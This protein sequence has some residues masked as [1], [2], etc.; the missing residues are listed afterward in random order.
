[1]RTNSYVDTSQDY[2]TNPNSLDS[3]FTPSDG[4]L[5]HSLGLVRLCLF[6]KA[7]TLNSAPASPKRSKDRFSNDYRNY[8]TMELL[9]FLK[10]RKDKRA[11]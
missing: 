1:L 3:S 11:K 4:L 8:E 2:N 10:A 6:D 9:L 5:V 7:C